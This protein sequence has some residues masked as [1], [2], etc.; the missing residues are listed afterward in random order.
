MEKGII[1]YK[2]MKKRKEIEREQHRDSA[3]IKE[4]RKSIVRISFDWGKDWE[5][6]KKGDDA[7][8]VIPGIII[9]ITDDG[10]SLIL[11]DCRFFKK[12]T[13]FKVNFPGV[14]GYEQEVECL[15]NDMVN[16]VEDYATFYLKPNNANYIQAATFECE[17]QNEGDRVHAFIFPREHQITPIGYCAGSIM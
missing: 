8:V 16:Y 17:A 1:V 10:R 3:D 14:T 7:I 5:P 15:T 4:V 2:R 11:A 13:N 9:S 12:S 6:I